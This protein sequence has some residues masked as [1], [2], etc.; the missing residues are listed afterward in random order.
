MLS[1]AGRRIFLACRQT[2]LRR[3]INGLAT[4]VE[5]SFKL[6]PFGESV[7]VFCNKKSERIKILEWDGDGFWL[8]LKHLEKGHFR[9]PAAGEEQTLTLSDEDLS[10]LIGGTRIEL[11]LKREEL[12][13][14]RIT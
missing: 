1:F 12:L 14:R 9:W 6:G 4:R 11:K 2:D 10:I 5:S 7:F 8:H 13:G 3:S